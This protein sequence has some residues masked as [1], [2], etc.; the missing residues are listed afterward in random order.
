MEPVCPRGVFVVG[1]DTGV[2]KTVVAAGL[3][4]MLRRRGL[5]VA[6]F[7]PFLSGDP[8]ALDA[9]MLARAAGMA[10]PG[11]LQPALLD[12]ISPFRFRDPVAPG[13]AARRED[14]PIN[15]ADAVDEARALG[16][17]NDVMVVEGAG[18]LF[19]PL[20]QTLEPGHCVIDLVA[21]MGLPAVVVARTALGTINHTV[22]TVHALRNRG[23]PICALI[24]STLDPN[25]VNDPDQIQA[26]TNLSG[27]TPACTIPFT[28]GSEAIMV[29]TAARL[30]EENALW[31]RISDQR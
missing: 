9:Q 14:R 16:A 8:E 29:G 6:V 23:I 20:T 30:F 15:L 18:G 4:R 22:M 31:E 13:I 1:T 12:V 3:T 24:M 2:G 17:M 10:G 26:I 5:R 28:T 11:V 25:D 21:Q 19:V 7:K 27:I